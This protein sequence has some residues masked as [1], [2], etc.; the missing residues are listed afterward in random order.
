[1]GNRLANT[2]GARITRYGPRFPM[3][4]YC[5]IPQTDFKMVSVLELISASMYHM[6]GSTTLLRDLKGVE[7][8]LTCVQ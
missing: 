4:L 2:A 7:T 1:M 6:R 5:Q 8:L 3:Q